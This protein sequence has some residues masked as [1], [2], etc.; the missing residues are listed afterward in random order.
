[1]FSILDFLLSLPLTVSTEPHQYGLQLLVVEGPEVPG[2]RVPVVAS[3]NPADDVQGPFPGVP[4][5]LVL[6]AG[7]K[8]GTRTIL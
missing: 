1:M 2:L 8:P 5:E 3:V 4:A 6:G 7:L